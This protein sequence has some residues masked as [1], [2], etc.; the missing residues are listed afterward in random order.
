MYIYNYDIII[1]RK[2]IGSKFL[3][4]GYMRITLAHMVDDNTHNIKIM[5]K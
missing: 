3:I 4:R 1:S 2:Q 5:N